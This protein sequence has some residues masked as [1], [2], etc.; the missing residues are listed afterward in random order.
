MNKIEG[1]RYPQTE[2]EQQTE[3]TPKYALHED[4]YK[5]L[6]GDDYEKTLETYREIETLVSFRD[7]LKQTPFGTFHTLIEEVTIIKQSKNS[8]EIKNKLIKEFVENTEIGLS[9]LSPR[10]AD[11]YNAMTHQLIEESYTP[12]HKTTAEQLEILLKTGDLD[13][14]FSPK[15]SWKIKSNRIKT[16]LTDYLS[17]VRSIDKRD[18]NIMDDDTRKWREEQLKKA[19]SK[20]PERQNESKPGVDAMERL[21]EGEKV[22]AIWSITPAYGGYYKERS[23]SVWNDTKNV[24][25]EGE[26]SYSDVEVVALCVEEDLKKGLVNL[27]MSARITCGKWTSL[28]TPYT[29]SFHKI[30]AGSKN[31]SIQKDQNGDLIIFVDGDGE[32]LDITVV[33]SPNLDKRFTSKQEDIKLPNMPSEFSEETN[34][35]LEH[36]KKN[37]RGNL[38]RAFATASYVKKRI[39]YL[40]PKD[41]EESDYYNSFYNN[42]EKGFSSAVDE[43]KKADC[44]VANTYFAALCS[45]INI[46]IRHCIGHSVKGK[47]EQNASNIN[48]GT[49]HGWSEVW[50]EVKK[51]WKRVDA[52]PPG[53]S[54][55]EENEEEEE[56][57]DNIPGDYGEQEAV[58]PTNE[59]LEKLREKLKEHTEKL[60]Y[61]KEERE[62]AE[63]AGIEHKEARQIV[64]EIHEAE[65]TRLPNGEKIVDALSRLFNTIVESRKTLVSGYE[66]PVRRRE[67]GEAIEDIV[68]HSIGV[69]ARET[70]PASREKPKEKTEEKEFIGGFDLYIIADKSGSMHSTVDGKPLWKMQRQAEYLIFSS[71]YRFHRNL[72]RASLQEKNALSVR[73]QGVSF[74]GSGPDEIDLDKQ[75]SSE[76]SS[77]DKVKL[78]HSLTNVGGG[79]GDVAALA[80]VY[81]QIKSESEEATKNKK[82]TK[83]RL[84]IACSDGGYTNNDTKTM[85]ELS[86]KLGKLNTIVVGIGLTETAQ[87]VREV[88]DNPPYSYG[89]LIENVDDLPAV[90]AKYLVSEIIKLFP[91]KAG[92]GVQ[93]I[94]DNSLHK[95]K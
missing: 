62:L 30:E 26:S 33:L 64:K 49:G 89:A 46:P 41:Q 95:F 57:S 28:P 66:G 13:V 40:A 48:S 42:H 43:I 70:D 21:K 35:Q 87:N 52:T 3:I 55:L 77:K 67:G 18:G 51:E 9:R 37:K 17:V 63:H 2:E 83:L 14:L 94:I 58:G 27:K 6:D 31:Y 50:D 75:L 22:P 24:W 61:T 23:F 53:D 74:R 16:R 78:W 79:N 34:N 19:P 92:Q 93:T 68:R 4:Y 29:H 80:Y 10:V 5:V 60:S 32:E 85:Q 82:D 88:M 81:E 72:K 36:I 59:E 15:T 39:T 86:K 38:A 12:K 7:D 73:T 56:S 1:R 84:V 20:P 91:K 8:K 76:F 45:K 47:D 69:R 44:D 11:L 71:L 90:V 25:T 65:N 54:Q